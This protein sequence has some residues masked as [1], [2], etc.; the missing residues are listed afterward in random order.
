[1]SSDGFRYEGRR[2]LVVG[3]ATGM[4]AAAAKTASELGADTIVMDIAPIDFPATQTVRVDLRDE[5]DIDTALGQIAAPIDA[6]FSCAGVADG[7]SGLM[8]I[9]FISQRHVID[10]LLEQGKLGGGAAAAVAM[11]S[12]GAGMGWQNNLPQALEFLACSDWESA[13]KW[14]ESHPGTDNYVFSKQVMNAYVAHESFAL[15]RKGVRLNAV[16]PGPTDTPLARANAD[17]WLPFGEPFRK[18]LGVGPLAPEHV[19]DTL[20]FL[21]S[22]AA[23]GIN[24][25]TLTIDY[26]HTSASMTGAYDD[27]LVRGLLGIG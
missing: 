11:I 6:I 18:E 19:G 9:N 15:A 21:C 13:S 12:S 17:V 7:T 24:G 14:I 4:G 1:M 2:V 16:L 8:L 3:G 26:G 25:V 5:N 20:A 23:S 27:P 10:R 22:D